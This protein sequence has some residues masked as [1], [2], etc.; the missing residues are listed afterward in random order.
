METTFHIVELICINDV[1]CWRTHL[2]TMLLLYK[3]CSLPYF[4][5][6]V[7]NLCLVYLSLLHC[8]ICMHCCNLHVDKQF[9]LLKLL[10]GVKQYSQVPNVNL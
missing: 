6:L 4:L 8:I 2:S 9:M 5:Q 3:I 10:I 7:H 1:F